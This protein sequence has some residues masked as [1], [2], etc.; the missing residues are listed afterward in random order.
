MKG[1]ART[2][3]YLLAALVELAALVAFILFG[4]SL[5]SGFPARLVAAATCGAAAVCM[6]GRYAAP[7]SPRRLP[8]PGL[9]LFKA[10]FFALVAMKGLGYGLNTPAKQLLYR[11]VARHTITRVKGWIDV[12]GGTHACAPTH[13]PEFLTHSLPHSLTISIG[14]GA[15]AAGSVLTS[16]ISGSI[17][18]LLNYGMA[19][20]L[21]LVGVWV[22]FAVGVVQAYSHRLALQQMQAE[23]IS[24]GV[25]GVSTSNLSKSSPHT[26]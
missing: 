1:A 11:P 5:F 9:I 3:N 10:M 19:I 14:R 18:R 13:R 25:D 22:A 12:F 16:L 8:M 23:T 6:W 7:R 17:E 21:A 4:W 20:N 15:K 26:K 2:L 24:S